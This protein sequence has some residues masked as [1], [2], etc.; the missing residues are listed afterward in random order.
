MGR[1]NIEL[2]E[3]LHKKLKVVCALKGITIKEYIISAV[4]SELSKS[5]LGGVLHE[6]K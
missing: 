2:P 1:I 3:E 5:N 6:K 4:E